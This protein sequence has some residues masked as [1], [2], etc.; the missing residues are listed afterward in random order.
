MKP[1]RVLHLGKFY[2]PVRGGMETALRTLCG[3]HNET[4]Q[5][6]ALV[7]NRA[8]KTTHEVVEGVKVTRAASWVTVGAVA[9]APTLPVWL[10]RAEADV[11]VIHEP[12]PMA[13][14]AYFIV[15]P[16]APLIVWYHSEVIRPDRRYRMFYRPLLDFALRRV[17]RVVVASPPMVDAPALAAL[18]EKCT[19]I[20][21]GLEPERYLATAAISERATT[22]R[23]AGRGPLLLFI[24]RL[25][26]YKGLDILIQALVEVDAQLAIVGDGPRR[27]EIQAR[28]AALGLGERVRVVGE[29]SDDERLAWLHACDA[30]VLPSTTRQEA[31]GMVQLEAMMCGRPVVSTDLP[32]GVPWVN[33][34]GMTGLVVAAGDVAALTTAL[35]RIVGDEEL[36]AAM[37]ARARQRAAT[38]FTADRMRSA[39]ANL[40]REVS[41]AC[42]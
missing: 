4:I 2:S 36:R 42:S 21:Y 41:Q 6:R 5:P 31:F 14:L 34:N 22:L 10:A 7:M 11:I 12:N 27:A 28:I 32:T 20:T 30:L 38:V 15:R 40:F 24:G 35:Q 25:V 29:V 23:Q 1:L 18:A 13:L 26:P 9:V 19:V 17:A 3:G 8:R 33:V 37:G 39:A 16:K